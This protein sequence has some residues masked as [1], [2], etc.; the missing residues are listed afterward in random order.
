M[1]IP[2]PTTLT[3]KETKDHKATVVMEPCYP[4]YGVTVG[5]SLRR[6]LLSSI[7]G[8]AITAFKIEGVQHEFTSLPFIK[9]DVV[10][11][12]LNLK[13]IRLKVFS[14]EPIVL[15]LEV[16]GEKTATAG[17]ITKN[18]QVEITTPNAPIATLTDKNATLKME[19][20]VQKGTGYVTVEDRAKEKADI[21]TVIIDALYTPVLNV[22]FEIENVR[23]GEQTDYEKLVLKIETDGTISPEIALHQ[24]TNIL[25]EHFQYV[26]DNTIAVAKEKKAK[27]EAA[28]EEEKAEKKAEETKEEPGIVASETPEEKSSS[29]NLPAPAAAGP[30]GKAGTSED[31]PSSVK[32][33][34]DKPK[35]KR[36]RPK[37]TES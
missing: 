1:R 34:E 25:V 22:G 16:E 29:A 33:S 17:D 2:L 31:K 35:K 14:D 21:G 30:A 7:E 12:M 19:I 5:N 10:E 26:L 4:G 11:I 20:T 37:K 23:V 18:S 27:K 13:N 36:G 24:A 28:K 32:T 3:I 8:A 9:E 6:V 15:N